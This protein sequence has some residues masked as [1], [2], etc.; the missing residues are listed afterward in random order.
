[1]TEGAMP[2]PE[3]E[4]R[5][6]LLSQGI[7]LVRFLAHSRHALG[8]T[9]IAGK[10]GLPNSSAFRLL[11]VLMELRFV[12]KSP[13]TRRY[14][15]SPEI[16]RFVHEVAHEFAP[17]RK[18]EVAMI[19]WAR[20]LD[21]A[22]YLSMLSGGCTYVVSAEGP[23]GGTFALGSAGPVYASS[24][25]KVIVAN[26][27]EVEWAF[28]EP[29]ERDERLTPY[30]NLDPARFRKELLAARESGVAWNMR[31]TTPEVASVAALVREPLHPPRMAVALLVSYEEVAVYDRASLERHVRELAA[32]LGSGCGPG[33]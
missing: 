25:G 8:V 10:M 32:E 27:P 2:R 23:M 9:E 5:K 7:D 26:L 17:T 14:T 19:R 15:I 30:T 20:E 1:M 29:T 24:A 12:Q 33:K 18:L 22:V 6:T 31:E 16:F 13:A 11:G 28:Y 4:N 21:C 3:T